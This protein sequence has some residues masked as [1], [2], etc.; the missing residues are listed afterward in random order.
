MIR[1]IALSI[2]VIPGIL[3]VY[4]IKLMRDMVFGILQ[5]PFPFLWLQFICGLLFVLI[6]I[7]FIAGFILHRD[8]K[9]NK[10][11]DKFKQVEGKK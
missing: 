7:G 1:I 2:L 6:G 3:A 11:Q 5:S 9:R 4:G 8:R 10:V